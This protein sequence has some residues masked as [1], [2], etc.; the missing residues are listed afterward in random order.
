MGQSFAG[1][2]KRKIKKRYNGQK[3][4]WKFENTKERATGIRQKDL[5]N[6]ENALSTA[7]KCKR[8]GRERRKF[9][10]QTREGEEKAKG[11]NRSEKEINE[12]R[13]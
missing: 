13:H 1:N 6:S 10:Q 8:G 9:S 11:E 5:E 2:Q 4:F 7:I 3:C 12:K